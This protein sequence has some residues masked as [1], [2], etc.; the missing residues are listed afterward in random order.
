MGKRVKNLPSVTPVA[1]DNAVLSRPNT[2]TV[3]ASLSD[4]IVLVSDAI[5]GGGG[6]S[7]T[8]TSVQASGGTTGLSFSGGPVT[9]S[10]TLT[11]SGTLAVANGGTGATDAATAR[12]NLGA[13]TVT[14]VQASG[15]TTGLSF[16]GGPVTGSG[17]FTLSGTLAVA[18]GGT[19]ATDAATARSNLGAAASSH[20]HSASDIASGTVATARLGS[21]TANSTTYLRGDNTW[22]TVSASSPTTTRGDL[23]RRGASAD[24]RMAP[25]AF[26]QKVLWD[27]T[28]TAFYCP[29]RFAEFFD[30]LH[31]TT[32]PTG[33]AAV[34]TSNNGTG[35]TATLQTGEAT[36]PGI[37]RLATGSG[38]TSANNSRLQLG[39]TAGFLLGGATY[40]LEFR[41]RLPSLS[42]ATET[43]RI[44]V[45]F[46]DVTAGDPVDG[47]CF[48]YTHGTNS[49][50]FV[51]KVRSNSSTVGSDVNGTVGPAANT[52]VR[53]GVLVDSSASTFKFYV[54]GTL[55]GTISGSGPTAAGRETSARALIEASGGSTGT[56]SDLMEID[57]VY[58]AYLMN[59]D[60]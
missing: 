38:P 45:G 10:G 7:G 6:G 24:E 42:N 59:S 17:T 18:N 33:V 37:I 26:A 9:T 21:G 52:W 14:S 47:A 30:D 55:D 56:A 50:N 60:R 19:G 3:L 22:A 11:L 43:F 13:G 1:S 15:G 27:G 53:L 2:G 36:A 39:Q 54:N 8:V 16:S 48:V 35:A 31:Y 58:L 32:I 23:I 5:G 44:N 46:Y 57:Y 34:L 40:Y 4:L 51:Y 29:C 25:S 28:D 41:I 49:G 12:S 20:T